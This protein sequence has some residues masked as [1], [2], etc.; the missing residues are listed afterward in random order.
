M[1]PT[2]HLVC[3]L[4]GAGKTTLAR[5]LEP[6]LPALRLAADDRREAGTRVRHAS[7]RGRSGVRLLCSR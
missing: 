6:D 3:G 4:T 7:R 5:Q 1:K 2:L